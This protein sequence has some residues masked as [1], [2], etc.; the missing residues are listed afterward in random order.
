MLSIND[1]KHFDINILSEELIKII[2][3]FRCMGIIVDNKNYSGQ[4]KINI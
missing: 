2:L 3:N 4:L 1:N